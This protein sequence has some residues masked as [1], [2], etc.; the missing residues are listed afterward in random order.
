MTTNP[1]GQP[2]LLPSPLVS[3]AMITYN[4]RPYIAQ[5]LDSV[6]AQRRDFPIE[7]VISDDCSPDGAASIIDEYETVHPGLF[8]RL[9]PPQ[10]LGAVANFDQVWRACS[11]KYIALLE[12]DDWWHSP[13]K[14]AIQVAFMERHLECTISGHLCQICNMSG[15]AS[16]QYGHTK[17][18]DQP[19]LFDAHDLIFGSNSLMT[20][21][22]MCRR[23]VVPGLPGWAMGMGF[24]DIP[25]FLLHA[26]R[27]RIGFI[28]QP[29]STYRVHPGGVW[30][31]KSPSAHLTCADEGY[32]AM[33][34]NFPKE[35]CRFFDARLG[36]LNQALFD[37][38]RREGRY[39]AARC[40]LGQ[41]VWR[42]YRA[43]RLTAGLAIRAPIWLL[44][45][46][47]Q[48]LRSLFLK[49]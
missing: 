37:V 8:R 42:Y 6:L 1:S 11:G 44:F 31:S 28:N 41:A 17:Q 3:V 46:G 13:E 20:P 23:G 14:L 4:H 7:I 2:T 29:L 24:G 18:T 45:P 21:S 40:H 49:R 26:I 30:T 34:S 38:Y 32:K 22:V 39:W 16:L 9:D 10:N 36:A 48:R 19:E 35:F 27:G 15:Q 47:V 12:G 5:A 43:G 25:L 33:R